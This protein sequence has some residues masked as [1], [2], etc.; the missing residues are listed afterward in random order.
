MFKNINTQDAI[1]LACIL[2]PDVSIRL[3]TSIPNFD[4]VKNI[5]QCEIL[6]TLYKCMWEI[7]RMDNILD[8]DRVVY[9]Y[10]NTMTKVLEW[11]LP[12]H[13]PKR[14]T[15]LDNNELELVVRD[16]KR[17]LAMS[18][19]LNV[20]TKQETGWMTRHG[21]KIKLRLPDSFKDTTRVV[22]TEFQL[23]K[24]EWIQHT[25]SDPDNSVTF[26]KT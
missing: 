13:T 8:L 15:E 16:Y 25:I 2:S 19:P 23:R 17:I 26:H 12:I 11:S 10:N 3:N 7:E 4:D 24:I 1:L 20:L 21:V 14:L 22:A 5:L 18:Y 6:E 9:A